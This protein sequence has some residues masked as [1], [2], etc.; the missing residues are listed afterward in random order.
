M[1]YRLLVALDAAD[2]NTA[3]F[4]RAMRDLRAAGWFDD[5]A[6]VVLGRTGGEVVSGYTVRDAANDVLGDLDIPVVYD[7]DIGHLPP[8][9]AWVQGA[10][11]ALKVSG[12][13]GRLAQRL[14]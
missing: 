13:A 12:G 7:A 3:Q 14:A 2:F 10:S 1:H 6:A 8:Q 5:A 11:A 4:A 9:M